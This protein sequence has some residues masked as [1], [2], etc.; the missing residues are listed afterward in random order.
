MEQNHSYTKIPNVILDNLPNYTPI[1]C[2]VMMLI[3]RQTFGY[4]DTIREFSINDISSKIG[5]QQPLS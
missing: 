5:R 3:A 2:K 1:E 4:A